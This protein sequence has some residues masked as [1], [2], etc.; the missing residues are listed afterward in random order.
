MSFVH[1]LESL[2]KLQN[3]IYSLLSTNRSSESEECG[4][5]LRYVLLVVQIYGLEH[6]QVRY[7]VVLHRFLETLQ[8]NMWSSSLSNYSI[9]NRVYHY[10][11]S[12]KWP[13]LFWTSFI[14]LYGIVIILSSTRLVDLNYHCYFVTTKDGRKCKLET[15]I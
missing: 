6:V 5:D 12:R 2:G 7:S 4:G 9:L 1:G 13:S 3:R 15:V 8:N 10:L 14:L 11:L